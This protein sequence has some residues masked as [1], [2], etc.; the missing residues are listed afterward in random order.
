MNPEG[1]LKILLLQTPSPP[2]LRIWRDNG[3]GMGTALPSERS[4]YGSNDGDFVLPYLA[5]FNCMSI[6][7]SEGYDV[8]FLDGQ[9]EGLTEEKTIQAIGEI[10]PDVVVGV[11]NLP[12]IYD[13]CKLLSSIKRA[14]PN[15]R[16]VATGS[17]C[18]I[19]P[20]EILKD[21]SIDALLRGDPEMNL[22][23]YLKAVTSNSAIEEVSGVAF[24]TAGSIFL[25]PEVPMIK[26]MTS[27]P[28]PPVS[29]APC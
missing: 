13:D 9:L 4:T 1:R 26:D 5:L 8:E 19:F 14:H 3:G 10:S 7:L 21:A 20:E 23:D 24:N 12:S 29:F 25:H 16:V 6:L 22:V 15:L 2:F 27:I 18:K 11:V 17:I 28:V